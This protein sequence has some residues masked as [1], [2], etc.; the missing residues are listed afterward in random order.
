MKKP[1][2][3][4]VEGPDDKHVIWALLKA[5]S[6]VENFDVE[7]K[8]GISN[9]LKILPVQLKGSDIK[10]VGVVVDADVD[11][12]AR[13]SAIITRLHQSGYKSA[14]QK[15]NEGGTILTEVGHPKVGVWIMPDNKLDGMLE[16]FIGLLVPGDDS[17]FSHAKKVIDELP[18]GARRFTSV[19]SSKALIHT[20]LAW[21]SDPGT[22]MGLALTKKFLDPDAV[23]AGPFVRWLKDLFV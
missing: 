17:G 16:D 13:W 14:P 4:L 23:T 6:V 21:Q 15:P 18:F 10:A 22:P 7:D 11:I 2:V 9:V 1:K 8:G 12:S 3:L 5:H 20:W 19:N